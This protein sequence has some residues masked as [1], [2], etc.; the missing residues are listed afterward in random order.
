MAG[1]R[2]HHPTLRAKVGKTLTYVVELPQ[3]YLRVYNC[4][5]CGKQHANKAVHLNIDAHGDTIVAKPVYESLKKAFLGG[6]EVA[7]DVAKPPPFAVGAV[8][9]T[10]RMI[11]E[12]PL[13]TNH[14]AED[15]YIPGRTKYESRDRMA[16]AMALVLAKEGDNG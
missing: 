12:A 13:N 1:I 14:K 10:K 11:V 4:P 6:M 3:P 15:F 8:D 5:T 2:L 9:M 7:N 16:K